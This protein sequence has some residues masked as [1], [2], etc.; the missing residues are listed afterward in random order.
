M[1]TAAG[2][3]DHGGGNFPAPCDQGFSRD[4]SQTNAPASPPRRKYDRLAVCNPEWARRRWRPSSPVRPGILSERSGRGVAD[5]TEPRIPPHRATAVGAVVAICRHQPR[6][7]SGTRSPRRTGRGPA[8]LAGPSSQLDPLRAAR[9]R[10]H[11]GAASARPWW[12]QYGKTAGVSIR[13]PRPWAR[14]SGGVDSTQPAHPTT[15]DGGWD[16]RP[17]VRPALRRATSTYS[18]STLVETLDVVLP[19]WGWGA[20]LAGMSTSTN[21]LTDHRHAHAHAHDDRCDAA[22]LCPPTET[23]AGHRWLPSGFDA[24][25]F[26]REVCERSGVPVGVVDPVALDKLR[27]LTRAT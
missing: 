15:D 23:S 20:Y 24:V 8:N 26:T 22:S 12:C 14:N 7:V 10:H 9:P 21:L 27:T 3:G 16:S 13:R 18:N 1:C 17:P 4:Q 5:L 19:A 11:G 2:Q 25:S 6:L